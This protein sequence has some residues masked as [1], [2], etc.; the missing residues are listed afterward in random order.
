MR[1]AFKFIRKILSSIFSVLSNSQL[2]LNILSV[3]ALPCD[4]NPT[5][6][7]TLA[8]IQESIS[9]E[10]SFCN[11][12]DLTKVDTAI[13]QQQS[14][15]WYIYEDDEENSKSTDALLTNENNEE[16]Q[17]RQF[18]ETL[19]YSIIKENQPPQQQQMK[20][21]QS[22]IKSTAISRTRSNGSGGSRNSNSTSPP[23][24]Y[25]PVASI[26]SLT[27]SQGY[28]DDFDESCALIATAGADSAELL[29]PNFKRKNSGAVNK[30]PTIHRFSAG[31]ADKIERGIRAHLS[32]RSLRES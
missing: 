8:T 10:P 6:A 13:E 7:T 25:E 18:P 2:V 9:K 4:M 31:D 29:S 12:N 16:A 22:S 24:A 1:A 32:T 15:P 28:V 23:H 3:N 20:S 27:D 21:I 11:I 5:S 26:E 17:N 30:A 14:N 19:T